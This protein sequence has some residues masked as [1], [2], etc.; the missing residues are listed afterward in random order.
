MDFS[1]Y[2]V[3]ILEDDCFD[4]SFI[5]VNNIN[6]NIE[7]LF[8]ELDI[9]VGK[10]C[11]VEVYKVKLKQN[12]L[13]QFEI[14]VVKIF[15]YE[16]YVFWKMEKDIFLDINL[17]YENI[18][19]F[20][21]VEECKMELGKQYWLIIVFYVKGN[22]QEYLMWYVIS[23]EDLCKL[24]SFFVWGIVYFYSDYILCGRFKMFIVYRDFKSF[25]IFVKNDLICCLCDFGFFLCL[26]FILF[27][28]D[29]V[30]SGQV[31]IVRYMV[32]EVLEFRMNL[33]NVEFFKQIDVYFMVLVFWEMILC[34][35]VVGEVKDYEFLF[36]F[37]VWEY[38]CVE[39]MKDNV[40]RD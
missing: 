1:E 13:E 34:C 4:I 21:I 9:L 33:E 12:I 18:F 23:W 31:G 5:C 20:L 40:L 37:K 3:I 32:L 29:L 16:E 2:C 19:Q 11:F 28:D 26:D 8:I 17:K 15:F 38:F 14:V 36:G 10:G 22:L 39:S 30:N 7:L 25:N 24:G 27:V 35:N 6:Y